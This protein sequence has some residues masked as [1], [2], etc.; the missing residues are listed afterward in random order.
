MSDMY[1]PWARQSCKALARKGELEKENATLRAELAEARSQ[2][3]LFRTSWNQDEWE[4]QK[5]LLGIVQKLQIALKKHV[6]P[7]EGPLADFLD[8]LEEAGVMP[9]EG[10]SK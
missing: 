5:R 8:G 1:C 9:R 3:A 2:A 10:E 6:R 4:K 7:M